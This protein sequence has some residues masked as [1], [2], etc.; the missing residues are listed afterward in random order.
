MKEQF[1]TYDIA[2]KLKDKKFTEECMGYY[3]YAKTAQHNEQD[4]Y[5]G[6]FG[7]R[8]GECN[9]N[10]EYFYN[11]CLKDISN[12]NWENVAAPLWQQV[13]E[14]FREKHQIFIEVEKITF[15]NDCYLAKVRKFN[16]NNKLVRASNYDDYKT[17]YKTM[18]MAVKK[19]LT[20]IK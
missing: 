14:W 7:W 19:A 1:V 13:I 12:E 17:H 8:K 2:K 10:K 18:E 4:G 16:K 5:S 11:G 6:P 20:L 9:F 15:N 3:D